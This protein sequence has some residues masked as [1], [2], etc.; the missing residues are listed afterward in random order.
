MFRSPFYFNKEV[1][2]PE[3]E[4]ALTPHTISQV[5]GVKRGQESE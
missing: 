2:E 5:T 4:K 1:V 3:Y